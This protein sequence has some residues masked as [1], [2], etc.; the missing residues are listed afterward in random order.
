MSEGSYSRDAKRISHVHLHINIKDSYLIKV[1]DDLVKQSNAF[2]PIID[3][4][5]VK[6]GKVWNASK[7]DGYTVVGLVVQILLQHHQ[8]KKKISI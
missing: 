5:R 8:R 7:Q 6:V 1:K 3:I 4:L 2:N